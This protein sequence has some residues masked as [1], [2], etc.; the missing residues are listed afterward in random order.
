MSGLNLFPAENQTS[1]KV[2][3]LNFGPAEEA[4]VLPILFR[5]RESGIRCE[6]Y[7]DG[8]KIRKQMNY[9][10]KK[11]IPF[12]VLAGETEMDME[13]VTLRKMSTGEQILLSFGELI[14][15]VSEQTDISQI[16]TN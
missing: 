11:G 16:R 9:A 15:V 7:P 1:T 6:I 8:G 2:L 13:K 14:K 5:M 10:D 12:V 3:F 4:Y